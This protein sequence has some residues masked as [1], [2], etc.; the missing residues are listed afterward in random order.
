MILIDDLYNAVNGEVNTSQSGFVQP[1]LFDLM[2]WKVSMKLFK[3]KCREAERSQE[4]TDDIALFLK[5]VNIMVTVPNGSNYGRISYP[6]NYGYFMSARIYVDDKAATCPCPNS[7]SDDTICG[8]WGDKNAQSNIV[9]SEV[10]MGKIDNSRWSGILDH[11]RLKP[12]LESPKMTQYADGFKVA[13]KQ[14]SI[15]T[16]DYYRLPVRSKWNYIAVGDYFQFTPI[17]SVDLDWTADMFGE[18][19]D[20]L[21]ILYMLCLRDPEGFQMAIKAEEV[22]A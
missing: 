6:A 1:N 22:A 18:F 16:L 13:P 9:L 3:K 17:G 15:M 12:T 21:K 2:C 10:P 4:I 8:K 14:V 11:S 19:V 7:E 5:S 20:S